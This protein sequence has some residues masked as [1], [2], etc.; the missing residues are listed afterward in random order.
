MFGGIA[1][2]LG[3]HMF[4]GIVGR[5]LIVRLGSDTELDEPHVRPM[6]FT[7]RPLKGIFF[8]APAGL[9]TQKQLQRWLD[10]ATSFARTLPMKR[11]PKRRPRRFSL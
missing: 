4:G 2:M 3:D 10:R 6:D 8:V 11:R 5:D 7:G 9:E 1:F